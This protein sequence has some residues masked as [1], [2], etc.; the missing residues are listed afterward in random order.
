MYHWN[1]GKLWHQIRQSNTELLSHTHA[2]LLKH[3]THSNGTVTDHVPSL[4][5]TR[6]IV[7]WGCK[8]PVQCVF[9]CVWVYV[10]AVRVC[11]WGGVYTWACFRSLG[12]QIV[13]FPGEQHHT[14]YCIF[15][16]I[17]DH[18]EPLESI[19]QGVHSPRLQCQGTVPCPKAPGWGPMLNWLREHTRRRWWSVN[20]HWLLCS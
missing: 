7:C 11:V 9:L 4:F 13:I 12:A 6:T 10:N 17:K 18:S 5:T 1:G 16:L 15:K 3:T 14:E 20:E 19:Q 8:K 2:S